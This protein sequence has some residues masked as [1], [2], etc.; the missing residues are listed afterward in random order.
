MRVISPQVEI[1]LI[2]AKQVKPDEYPPDNLAW[3]GKILFCEENKQ[4]REKFHKLVSR[5]RWKKFYEYEGFN[6]LVGFKDPKDGKIYLFSA[7]NYVGSAS[8]PLLIPE[9]FI[10]PFYKDRSVV[11]T[12]IIIFIGIWFILSSIYTP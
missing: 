3:A 12:L 5:A 6:D 11:A 4:A 2:F 10:P 9:G 8:S 7:F 1:S